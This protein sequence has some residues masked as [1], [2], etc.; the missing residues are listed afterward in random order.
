[1]DL[2]KMTK[3]GL[4][5]ILGL[6]LAGAA[7]AIAQE[8]AATDAGLAS[9]SLADGETVK[10]IRMLEAQLEQ[11]PGDPAL[12]INLG[13]A[14]AH[15]GN[16]VEARAR[17]DA[18]LASRDVVELDTADGRTTNS[19]RLA[20]QAIAMLEKGAFRPA[21]RQTDQLTLRN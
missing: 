20:R 17:F 2:S 18:A 19:R 4:T 15:T 21:P 16:D 8:Q 5:M 12:L 1:M 9:A 7:P 13:I 11:Y 10:A 6:G 14:H 3:T